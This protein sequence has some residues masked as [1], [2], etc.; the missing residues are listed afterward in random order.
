MEDLTGGV[1]T[2]IATNSILDKERLW[3]ELLSCGIIG[4]EFLFT[5]SSGPGFKHR[6]GI[7]L[8]HTYSILEA[9]ELKKEHGGMT[10]LV[11]I[12]LVLFG[13]L[14]GI[15]LSLTYSFSSE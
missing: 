11:K 10:R 12:R 15:L 7:V 13:W 9:I 8:S 1:A 5:L 3:R 4:G 6:N 14:L 2:V